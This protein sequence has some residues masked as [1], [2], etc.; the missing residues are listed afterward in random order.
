MDSK[1]RLMLV[2]YFISFAI[3]YLIF[4]RGDDEG[5]IKPET[6]SPTN[7]L[8][9]N[10][11]YPETT[12]KSEW[13]S[14][15]DATVSLDLIS[16]IISYN[17]STKKSHTSS[18]AWAM[19]QN[20]FFENCSSGNYGV[21]SSACPYYQQCVSVVSHLFS[22]NPPSEFVEMDYEAVAVFIKSQ[23]T[24]GAKTVSKEVCHGDRCSQ[25]TDNIVDACSVV[26]ST[27][28]SQVTANSIFKFVPEIDY[29]RAHQLGEKAVKGYGECLCVLHKELEIE[30]D[31]SIG[32]CA[33]EKFIDCNSRNGGAFCGRK[34]RRS[35]SD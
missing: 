35:Q 1:G 15:K 14:G 7:L 8:D 2:L 30:D 9:C 20:K 11:T 19:D 18:V 26:S 23:N 17:S 16:G 24:S 22:K 5:K 21:W 12:Y 27:F 25:K 34:I 13:T 28:S 3:I 33:G 31:Y 32:Y 10:R 6:F 29:K 4:F